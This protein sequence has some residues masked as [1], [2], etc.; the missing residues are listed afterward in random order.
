MDAFIEDIQKKYLEDLITKYPIYRLFVLVLFAFGS[1]VYNSEDGFRSRVTEYLLTVKVD[2]IYD[3][4]AGIL[5]KIPLLSFIISVV[6][7]FINQS[8][9]TRLKDT[10]FK[11]LVKFVGQSKIDSFVE[12]LK[13]NAKSGKSPN[14]SV[15]FYISKDLSKQLDIHRKKLRSYHSLAEILLAAIEVLLIGLVGLK[16]VDWIFI[17]VSIVCVFYMQWLAFNYYI[18]W[19]VPAYATEKTLLNSKFEFGEE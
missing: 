12:Q 19:F 11:A 6:C 1:Y 13:N 15:N 10:I 14:E 7:V 17:F 2:F 5:T 4:E 9:Y 8:I 18:S 3:L 16:T